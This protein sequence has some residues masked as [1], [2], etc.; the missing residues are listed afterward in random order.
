[1]Y[2]S[3][4]LPRRSRHC[5]RSS[6]EADELTMRFAMVDEDAELKDS[7]Q[8][9]HR[10]IVDAVRAKRGDPFASPFTVSE[11]YQE[12]APYRTVR[13][14]LSFEMNADY[15]HALVRMLAGID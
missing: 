11:I 2:C 14:A 8:R 7:V 15:E 3:V 12:L 5:A 13:T 1:M 4:H 9:L 6:P 10:F